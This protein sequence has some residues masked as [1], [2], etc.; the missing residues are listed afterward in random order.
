MLK[1]FLIQSGLATGILIGFVKKSDP[2]CLLIFDWLVLPQTNCSLWDV[3][4]SNPSCDAYRTLSAMSE[5]HVIFSA[6]ILSSLIFDT[7]K[8]YLHCR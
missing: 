3:V 8:I 5:F 7:T 4:Q 6:A 1:I 2:N